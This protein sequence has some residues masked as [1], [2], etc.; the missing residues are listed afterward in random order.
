[1]ISLTWYTAALSES[2]ASGTCWIS[3]VTWSKIFNVPRYLDS[4]IYELL[5]FELDDW[6][7]E[8]LTSKRYSLWV[9]NV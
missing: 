1:M 8:V 7:L 6:E 3:C 5:D 4:T 9:F 2:A